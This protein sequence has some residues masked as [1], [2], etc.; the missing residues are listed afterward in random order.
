MA[1]SRAAVTFDVPTAIVGA[2]TICVITT[3]MFG[4]KWRVKFAP[5]TA[6]N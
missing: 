5:P 2:F 1:K 3:E 6:E 4:K